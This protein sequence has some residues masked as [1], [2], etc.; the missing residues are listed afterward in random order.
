M[1]YRKPG[2]RSSPG[3]RPCWKH[4]A[5]R[6]PGNISAFRKRFWTI[7]WEILKNHFIHAGSAGSTLSPAEPTSFLERCPHFPL[8]FFGFTCYTKAVI[9]E[10]MFAIILFL[11]KMISSFYLSRFTA[12]RLGGGKKCI[13]TIS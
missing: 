1:R 7:S 2:R 13:D 3:Y 5:P 4:S 9:I 10:I 8:Y 12:D 6:M 11:N